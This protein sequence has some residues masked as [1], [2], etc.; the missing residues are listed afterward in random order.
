MAVHPLRDIAAHADTIAG[1]MRRDPSRLQAADRHNLHILAIMCGYP[2]ER[3]EQIA[4]RDLA[5]LLGTTLRNPQ[6][7]V[8]IAQRIARANGHG[9]APRHNTPVW[10]LLDEPNEPPADPGIKI[11][12]APGKPPKNP[13][14]DPLAPDEGYVTPETLER[15]GA[16]ILKTAKEY[17]DEQDA[18]QYEAI[19][20]DMKTFKE[21]VIPDAVREALAAQT[22]VHLIVQTPSTPLPVALGLVHRETPR[23]IKALNAGLNVYLHGPA[24]SGKTTVGQK[25]AEAFGLPF[26]TAAKVESEY[27]LLGFRDAKGDVVRTPFREAY[28]HGGVFLFDELDGSSPGAVV[29]LNMALANGMCPFP[30]GL[31]ARHPD[32]KVIAAGNTTLTGGNRQYAGRMQMD[33]ASIDRF[34]F[35]RFGY[36]EALETELAQDKAWCEYVQAIRAAVAERG[37]SHLVTPRATFDGCKALAA[38]LTWE[39]A[40][41]GAL[42]KGLDAEAADELRRVAR[43]TAT[44]GVWQTRATQ[45]A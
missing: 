31:I 14:F 15:V 39:E 26:Y 17:A 28:E 12:F 38:G 40:E 27:L 7:G 9:I 24:G 2:A 44:G 45:A 36:D 42:F 41:E 29:A 18:E 37:M 23:I 32:F 25:C 20:E 13:G 19:L 8:E 11:P 3:V 22:A 21:S 5:T 10:N 4:L 43:N 35:I 1:L 6:S 30:D 16:G 34:F 33:G